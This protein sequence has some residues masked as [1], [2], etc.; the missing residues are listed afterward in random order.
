VTTK[1]EERVLATVGLRGFKVKASHAEDLILAEAWHFVRLR[2]TARR[3]DRE[4]QATEWRKLKSRAAM[5]T[6]RVEVAMPVE[7]DDDEVVSWLK[8]AY[9]ENA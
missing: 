7:V 9:K 2:A 6:A 3:E 4:D 8:R 5:V 1:R